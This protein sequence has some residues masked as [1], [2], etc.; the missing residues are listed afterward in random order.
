MKR[1]ITYIIFLTICEISLALYLTFWRNSFWE[2]VSLK[3][4]HSFTVELIVFCVI[5]LSFCLVTALSGYFITLCAIK[6]RETLTKRVKSTK[7][8]SKI[9]N[10]SQR[11]QQDTL[12]YPD[13]MLNI[14][15][16]SGKALVYI[17]VFSA[18]LIY[19]FSAW[20]LTIIIFYAIISTWVAKKIAMPLINLNYKAQVAEAT[21][22]SLLSEFNFAN[23]IG[24][25]TQMAIKTK[26]LNYFQTFYGQI[27]VILPILIVAP[28]YF[29]GAMTLG[30]LMQATSTMSTISD[31]CSY[32]IT[33]FS[34]INR[35]L[36]C[37]KRL[38]EIKII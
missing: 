34:V 17:I 2:S 1:Y 4:L 36:S 26:H 37:R 10:F 20:Y 16:G 8:V 27:A 29:G 12:D 21:Y 14:L 7:N 5:A 15:F 13:L 31:N 30:L 23:C 32:G 11:V 22:R 35:L 33:S 9:E 25:M 18:A 19:N 3:N 38:K 24:I 28:A 6:W